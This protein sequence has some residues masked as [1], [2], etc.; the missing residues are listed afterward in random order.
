MRFRLMQKHR[1]HPKSALKSA[2]SMYSSPEGTKQA[3][4]STALVMQHSFFVYVCHQE[5]EL[6]GNLEA[7][8]CLWICHLSLKYSNK[9]FPIEVGYDFS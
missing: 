4:G 8:P 2:V 9:T 1:P 5:L 7:L 6:V 3:C